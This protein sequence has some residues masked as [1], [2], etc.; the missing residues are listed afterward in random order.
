MYRISKNIK[1]SIFTGLLFAMVMQQP[2]LAEEQQ[3]LNPRMFAAV[4]TSSP[5]FSL[6]SSSSI[7]WLFEDVDIK[8]DAPISGERTKE[9]LKQEIS[10]EML[11]KGFTI[12]PSGSPS[13]YY[14][15]FTAATE[16]TLDDAT[17]LKRYKV[18]PGFNSAATGNRIYEK[19]TLLI[20][21]I[22]AKTRQTVWQSV[23]QANIKADISDDQRRI[24]IKAI[25]QSML[26]KLPVAR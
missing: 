17:L 20:H 4:S 2:L 19:G 22:D 15:A 16:S 7:S 5:G 24:N 23:V 26:R 18:S 6:S 21:I 9:A 14:V 1:S 11:N 10:A 13:D 25:I 3:Q 12:G 8:Q